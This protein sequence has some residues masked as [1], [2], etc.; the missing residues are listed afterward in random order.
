MIPH[1]GGAKIA[2]W[3]KRYVEHVT[4][5][6]AIVEVGCWLGAVTQH[7]VG[8]H[9]VYVYD[10]FEATPSEVEKAQTF[11]LEL[12]A[13]Q[14]TLPLVK[15]F[16]PGPWYIRGDIRDASYAGPSIGLYID[17]ASKRQ[18]LWD[19]S[20][21]VFEPYFIPGETVLFLMDFDYPLCEAQREHA[22]KWT[23]LE[24]GVGG[25]SCAILRC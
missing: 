15:E 19:H 20:M 6:R 23:L 11:G 14:N 1:M 7:L 24:R 5:G 21:S 13:G 22:K 17:D 10:A 16:V 8:G 4:P 9:P 2:P 3:L 12:K 18:K 25:T